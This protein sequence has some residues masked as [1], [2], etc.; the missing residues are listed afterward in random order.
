MWTYEVYHS[1]QEKRF[2][3]VYLCVLFVEEGFRDVS[4]HNQKGILEE[5][6]EYTKCI[7]PSQHNNS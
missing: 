7:Y 4:F 1:I 2:P 5:A 3:K 6:G